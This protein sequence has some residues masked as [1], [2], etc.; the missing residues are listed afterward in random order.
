MLHLWEHP[1]LLAV[2]PAAGLD[3]AVRERLD[4]LVA[5]FVA[6]WREQN[7]R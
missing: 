7:G 5:E 4:R 3:A 1:P 2:A 6:T